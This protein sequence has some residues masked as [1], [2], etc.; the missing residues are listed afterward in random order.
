MLEI[1][2]PSYRRRSTL[3]LSGCDGTS[4]SVGQSKLCHTTVVVDGPEMTRLPVSRRDMA[5]A[6][7]PPPPLVVLSHTVVPLASSRAS[8]PSRRNVILEPL[9]FTGA[10]GLAVQM[11]VLSAAWVYQTEKEK[12]FSPASRKPQEKVASGDTRK[13]RAWSSTDREEPAPSVCCAETD[14]HGTTAMSS[15][16]KATQCWLCSCTYESTNGRQDGH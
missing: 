3:S 15:E 16:I 14:G 1:S 13:G 10:L 4:V 7:P 12:A 6:P 5:M 9:P 11:G 8:L 2:G